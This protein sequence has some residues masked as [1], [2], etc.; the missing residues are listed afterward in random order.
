MWTTDDNDYRAMT[1][2]E[3]KITI[4][5]NCWQQLSGL[6]RKFFIVNDKISFQKHLNVHKGLIHHS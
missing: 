2:K 6:Q 4:S 3:A 1:L 5:Y